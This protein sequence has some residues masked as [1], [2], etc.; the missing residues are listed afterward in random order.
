MNNINIPLFVGSPVEEPSEQ[1]LIRRLRSDLERL[2]VCATLYAN[3]FPEARRTRQVD[4]LVRTR[5]RTA[6]VEIKDLRRDYPVRGG[7]NGLWTQ[8]LPDGTQRQL[9]TNCGRQALDGTFAISDAMRDLARKSLVPAADDGFK[10]HIDSIVGMWETIPEDSDIETPPYVTVAGYEELLQRLTKAGPRVPW[11]DEHWDV[12]ARRNHLYQPETES[13]IERRRRSSHEMVTDYRLL[14][15][16]S[17][18]AEGLSRFVDLGATDKQGAEYS[19]AEVCRRVSGGAVLALVGPSGGG[20]TFF[21]KHLAVNHCHD[22]RLVVWIRASAYEGRFSDLLA[23][24]MAPFGVQRWS[25]LVAAAEESGTAI[26]AVLDGLNECPPDVRS[27]LLQ[28]LRA[29][30]LRHPASVLITSTSGDGLGTTAGPE[31]LRVREPDDRS[32]Q[33]MLHAY[34]AEHPERISDQFRSPHELAVAAECESELGS[35]ASVIDLHDAYIRRSARSEQIRAGLRSLAS[36]MHSE[37]RTSLPQHQ[38]TLILSSPAQGLEPRQADNVLTCDLLAIDGHRVRF[39][40]ELI[41]QFLAAED[42][43][44][45]ADSGE[46]LGLSLTSP[47][48][49]VLTDVALGIERDPRR[50]WDAL[51]ALARPDLLY[52]A[53]DKRYGADVADTAAQ[54]VRDMLQRANASTATATATFDTGGGWFGRWVTERGW[55]EFERALLAAAGQSLNLGLFVDEV[56]ELIDRTDEFCL[57]HAQSLSAEGDRTP[58]TRVFASTYIPPAAPSDGHGLAATYVV[59]AFEVAKTDRRSSSA[60]RPAGL[61]RRFATGAH[62]RSWGRFYLAILALDPD[63]DLDQSLFPTLL[64]QA[65]DADGYHLRLEA[66]LVAPY[67]HGSTEPHR[68]EILDG[69]RELETN[70]FQLR[71]SIVEALACFDEI[72]NPTTVEELKTYIRAIILNPD[73]I[74]HCQLA[75]GI[76]CSQFEDERIFGPFFTAIDE[77]TRGEKV[78]LLMMAARGADPS[79]SMS[80]GWTL[81]QLVD[82]VPTGNATI[83]DE[84]KTLFADVLRNGPIEDALVVNDAARPC[85]TAL[86]GWAKFSAVLPPAADDTT[87]QQWNWHLVA[88]LLLR[89]ERNDSLVDPDETWSI[90]LSDLPRTVNTLAALH[91]ATMSM[92][93]PAFNHLINDYADPLRTLFQW[94]LDNSSEIPPTRLHPWDGVER[95]AIR[96]LGEVGN[97]STAASLHAHTLDPDVADAAVKAIRQIRRRSAH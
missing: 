70:H 6:H 81:E 59:G 90:L 56:C 14:L 52:C 32:R 66:L 45:T 20:K 10:R 58:V 13:E 47:A 8:L 23:R 30:T 16:G 53:L 40:H 63:D 4:L 35:D 69:L 62:A 27:E 92:R 67:F 60:S 36:R 15:A 57:A 71:S 95:F 37:L 74:E 54:E 38:A 84:A 46:S 93:V 73:D 61:A 31:T 88:G 24:A 7:L 64:R 82:L 26:T 1:A 89:Y 65:W 28:Q 97:E 50:V 49:A 42:L 12:F 77:L 91:E 75:D 17:S 78:R 41:G 43:V 44:R 48:N 68:S 29:F 9:E 22:G 72:K 80:L 21:A 2:G 18:L 34:G 79:N 55:T 3:F 86:R 11:T 83:D 96:M 5:C 25:T 51:R 19:A 94:A 76:I 87:P 85:F 33:E 39:R